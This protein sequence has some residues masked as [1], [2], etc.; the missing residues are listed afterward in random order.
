M[1]QS[2]PLISVIIPT[3]NYA[4][5]LPD[6][7]HSVL[8]QPGNDYELIVVNDGSTDN[9]DE[10]VQSLLSDENH[11]FHYIKQENKGLAGARNTGIERTK[12]QY[13]FFLDSDDKFTP[14]AF[15]LLR[16]GIKQ[17]P[18]AG[19]IIGRY[20]SIKPDGY[21]KTRCLWSLT[22]TKEG[23]F[24]QYLLNTDVS[25]LC[26]TVLFNR[27]VF[28][29]YQFPNH[30]RQCEDESVFAYIFANYDIVKIQ[31]VISHILKH[32]DSL[33]NHVY[34]DLSNLIVDE[35]FDPE[36]IPA[37]LLKYKDSYRGIRYLDQFRTLFLAKEY[38]EALKYYK[39]AYK[40][41]KKVALKLNFL[42]KA[43]KAYFF[44]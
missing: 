42:R 29:S 15:N 39:K 38:N 3:Y 37:P 32:D 12:G 30:I 4:H 10:V 17:N 20:N 28:E 35:V 27:K 13:L 16:N 6:T 40:Y 25:L 1:T 24:S 21:S 8:Q 11:S 23:N 18:N 9:T 44:K 33:R 5:Y 31:G 19:M 26:S 2:N 7:I 22:G 41:N 36:R 14:D 34:H 43:V